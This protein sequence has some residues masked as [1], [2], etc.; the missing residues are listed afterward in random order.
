MGKKEFK[1]MCCFNPSDNS[2]LLE[3]NIQQLKKLASEIYE[4]EGLDISWLTLR[5]PNS[6]WLKQLF[7]TI[8]LIISLISHLSDSMCFSLYPKEI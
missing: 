2:Q 6:E 1:G 4:K 5:L 8:L 7:I 3:L